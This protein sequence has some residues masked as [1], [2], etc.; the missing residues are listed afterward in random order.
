MLAIYRQFNQGISV[1]GCAIVSF[2]T[3]GW[4]M[5]DVHRIEK[6][7]IRSDYENKISNYEKEIHN[8]KQVLYELENKIEMK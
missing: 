6:K 4:M 8:L 7:Q 3:L 5:L 2:M 1:A